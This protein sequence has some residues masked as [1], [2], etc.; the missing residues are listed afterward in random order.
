[1]LP[2]FL[3]CTNVDNSKN[4]KSLLFPVLCSPL[5]LFVHKSS[6][7]D[8][9]TTP[10]S[11]L[12]S[13][14]SFIQLDSSNSPTANLMSGI[15]FDHKSSLSTSAPQ[16]SSSLL[17]GFHLR[18][19]SATSESSI[20]SASS[21]FQSAPMI[22]S[23]M[24]EMKTPLEMGYSHQETVPSPLAARFPLYIGILL[25]SSDCHLYTSDSPPICVGII[26]QPSMEVELETNDDRMDI[27]EDLDTSCK[28]DSSSQ[29]TQALYPIN[30]SRNDTLLSPS[31]S[32]SSSAIKPSSKEGYRCV[33][34]SYS[35]FSFSERKLINAS[36]LGDLQLYPLSSPSESVFPLSPI[37]EVTSP[38]SLSKLQFI[39]QL[40]NPQCT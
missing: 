37:F 6:A 20:Y 36:L 1:M 9:G 11:L 30:F 14:F 38:F 29:L 15:K 27:E 31:T 3:N 28:Q 12:F 33:V 4:D 25:L 19:T 34:V 39:Q 32:Q 35:S 23:E 26:E 18:Q 13:S 2:F 16:T 10:F 21:L 17:A 24:S 7:Y 22:H 5:F 40:T 8:F